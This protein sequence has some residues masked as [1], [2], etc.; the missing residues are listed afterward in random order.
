MP[1]AGS[2]PNSL[3]PG[4]RV[5]GHGDVTKLRHMLWKW[6]RIVEHGTNNAVRRNDGDLAI[7][8]L[9]TG[10]ELSHAYLRATD[11]LEAHEC[12]TSFSHFEDRNGYSDDT[13]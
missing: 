11:H 13:H 4:S 6:L 2:K 5:R 8:W 10:S 9:R 7:L 3:L 12:F 1:V